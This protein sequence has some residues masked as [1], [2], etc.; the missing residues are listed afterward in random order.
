MF[1]KGIDY[2]YCKGAEVYRSLS[3]HRFSA[4][5]EEPHYAERTVCRNHFPI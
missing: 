4:M 3:D 1:M 2:Q 5:L